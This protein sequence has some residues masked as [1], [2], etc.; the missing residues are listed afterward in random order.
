MR[1]AQRFLTWV[2][3]CSSALLCVWSPPGAE[4]FGLEPRP[5][6]RKGSRPIQFVVNMAHV[7]S[8]YPEDEYVALINDALRPWTQVETADANFEISPTVIRDDAATRPQEDGVNM[9]LWNSGAVPKD[10]MTW[11]RAFPF[12][13]ECDVVVELTTPFRRANV[14]NTIRHE[15]GH[16]LGL[17]HSTAMSAMARYSHYLQGL[18]QD[19]LAGLSVLFPSVR[20]PLSRTTATI[21]GRVVWYNGDPVVGAVVSVLRGNTQEVLVSG[22]SGLVDGQRRRDASGAFELPG[23]PPGEHR[24]LIQPVAMFAGVGDGYHGIPT[25][26]PPMFK[27]VTVELPELEAGDE[28][29]VGKVTVSEP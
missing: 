12:A 24:L 11:G 10:A 7:P 26:A 19:D 13:H 27:P 17:S 5:A 2:A 22:F 29:D 9:I 14:E 15:F 6:W 1:M 20:H 25:E 23:V 3:G 16:C 18:T 4:A 8:T 21:R 28:T